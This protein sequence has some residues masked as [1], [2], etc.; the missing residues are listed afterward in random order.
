MF[1]VC[2]II[3]L[4]FGIILAKAIY[5]IKLVLPALIENK[6]NQIAIYIVSL[7][8]DFLMIKMMTILL[9]GIK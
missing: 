9:W 8:K 5:T 1:G 6:N 2:Q 3:H 7:G 4:D